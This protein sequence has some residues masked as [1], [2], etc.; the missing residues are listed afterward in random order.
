MK[1]RKVDIENF[2]DV[3][4][5]DEMFMIKKGVKKILKKG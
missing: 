4:N 2:R 1:L 3:I 5:K